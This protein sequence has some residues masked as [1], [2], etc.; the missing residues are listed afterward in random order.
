MSKI[1]IEIADKFQ[2]ADG[3]NDGWPICFGSDMQGVHWG[4]ITKYVRGSEA[5]CSICIM[6][7]MTFARW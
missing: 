5:S 4:I 7:M 3:K 1:L 2:V 6:V